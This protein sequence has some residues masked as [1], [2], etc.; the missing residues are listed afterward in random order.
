M[1][2]DTKQWQPAVRLEL[3]CSLGNKVRKMLRLAWAKVITNAIVH[4]LW[5]I[6]SVLDS[7]SRGRQFESHQRHYVVS[8]S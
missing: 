2:K 3:H 6:D 5:L 1:L 8:L 4:T 7:R